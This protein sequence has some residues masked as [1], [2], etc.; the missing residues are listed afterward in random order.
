MINLR[1]IKNLI[2]VLG[3]L[4]LLIP[5]YSNAQDNCKA[6]IQQL[7]DCLSEE[8]TTVDG[9]LDALTQQQ[10]KAIIVCISCTPT[11]Q[12]T[13]ALDAVEELLKAK[14]EIYSD[15]DAY[16]DAVICTADNL[17]GEI[18]ALTREIEG[19]EAALN[20][21]SGHLS[22]S[23]DGNPVS[24]GGSS[25]GGSAVNIPKGDVVYQTKI[26]FPEGA[27]VFNKENPG[28]NQQEFEAPEVKDSFRAMDSQYWEKI[29]AIVE[30]FM[31]DYEIPKKLVLIPHGDGFCKM[32]DKKTM[33]LAGGNNSEFMSGSGFPPTNIWAMLVR[34]D[35][36]S[37]TNS[38]WLDDIH[39]F[40]SM[41]GA[42]YAGGKYFNNSERYV[43]IKV[44]VLDEETIETSDQID[45]ALKRQGAK[46]EAPVAT[47]SFDFFFS[48]G[49]SPRDASFNENVDKLAQTIN[50][51][52]KN[53]PVKLL[54]SGFGDK[55]SQAGNLSAANKR[56]NYVINALKGKVDASKFKTIPSTKLRARHCTFTTEID[57]GGAN[58]SRKI[59]ITIKQ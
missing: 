43:E 17:E 2:I 35:I 4:V 14:A 55:G 58:G 11:S 18:A 53:E 50:A 48:S 45:E 28:L 3:I 21:G 30:A 26:L 54:V 40:D 39:D 47:G 16:N 8:G 46:P 59:Q 49:T 23:E 51:A 33:E 27:D 38:V 25:S 32:L 34:E 31:N 41:K 42:V 10:A 1:S 19:I 20:D 9:C 56:F 36:T 37:L 15:V 13:P 6:K 7:I 24:G 5:A 29:K 44:V 52:Y 22:L 57:N 12:R